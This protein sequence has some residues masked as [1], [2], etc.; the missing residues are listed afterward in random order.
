[1]VIKHPYL[2]HKVILNLVDVNKEITYDIK[3][4]K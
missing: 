1:M 4:I 3:N 2:F